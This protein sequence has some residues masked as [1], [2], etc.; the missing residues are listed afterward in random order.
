MSSLPTL[1]RRNWLERLSLGLAIAISGVAALTLAGW[2]LRIEELMQPFPGLA[3]FK[4]NAALSFLAIGLALLAMELGHARFAP[5]ALVATALGSLSL[6]QDVLGAEFRIDELL[7]RDFLALQTEHPGRMAA[8]LAALLVPSGLISAW[9]A[10]E[11]AARERLMATAVVGS[12]LAAAGLSTLLGYGFGLQTVYAWGTNTATSPI[13]AIELILLGLAQLALAWRQSS[14]APGDAPAWTPL[15]VV[16]GCVAVTVV[17]AFGL[18]AREDAFTNATTLSRIEQLAGQIKDSFDKQE[19]QFE[20][21]ARTWGDRAEESDEGWKA[22]A[23]VQLLERGSGELGCVAIGFVDLKRRTVWSES[24]DNSGPTRGFDHT[25]A[26][27]RRDAIALAESRRGPAVSTTT[28]VLVAGR[29]LVK[30]VVIYSPVI[31]AGAIT[32][33]LSAEFAYQEFFESIASAKGSPLRADYHVAVAI[34][35]ETVYTRSE[36]DPGPDATFTLERVY[37]LAARRIRIS[38]TP[39]AVALSRTRRPLPEFALVTGLVVTA[40]LG[41]SVHLYRSARTGQHAAEHSSRRLYAE[42]E[43]R[44]R[45]E[46]RLK[47]SDERLRLALD[48]T[49]IGIFEWSVAA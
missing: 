47:T 42:N 44:R 29:N 20:R 8:M 31:R 18:D 35:G 40:L 36:A 15:P 45:V 48:S 34:G 12:L 27:E 1:P 39:T 43:E 32:G 26:E 41:L 21:I 17:C 4:L 46:A 10:W 7:G 16:C 30:G 25:L 5:L 14:V 28:S 2:W 22:D 19:G 23:R 38:L 6:A 24:L 13:A 3:A 33:F 37:Q 9:H 49:Q 11:R